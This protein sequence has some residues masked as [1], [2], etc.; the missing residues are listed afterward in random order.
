MLDL[1]KIGQQLPRG[2][3]ELLEAILQRRVVQQRQVAGADAGDL[4]I[5][6][7]PALLELRNAQLRV[8]LAAGR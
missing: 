6:L 2:Q 8:G 3:H 5:D 7:V 1:A 4:G